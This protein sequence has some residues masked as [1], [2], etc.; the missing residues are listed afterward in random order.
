VHHAVEKKRLFEDFPELIG[1]ISEKEL[2][3]LV[4]LRGVPN[5]LNSKMHLSEIRL[6][7]N[8]F[9]NSFTH[10]PGGRKIPTKEQIFAQVKA[11][12]D[13]YG[14]LFYPPIR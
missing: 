4:S 3:S 9:Y 1:V 8:E 14:H 13:K 11:I 7:W 5:E 2:N 6:I 12:D 10:N